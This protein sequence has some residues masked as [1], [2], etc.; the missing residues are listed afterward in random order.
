MQ[1]ELQCFVQEIA[2]NSDEIVE[3]KKPSK[4]KEVSRDEY[5]CND[6]TK[7]RRIERTLPK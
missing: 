6:E 5:D 7:I 2:I 1:V 3:I 4:G